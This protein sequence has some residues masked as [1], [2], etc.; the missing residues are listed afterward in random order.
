[1]AVS[2]RGLE[3]EGVARTEADDRAPQQL[4][5]APLDLSLR[6]YLPRES[7]GG[8]YLGK[9]VAWVMVLRCK[10][11]K[12][13]FEYSANDLVSALKMILAAGYRCKEIAS[14]SLSRRRQNRQ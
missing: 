4:A 7:G 1:M 13:D 3:H 11:T 5:F 12:S 6:D 9:I 14:P 8:R 2:L 10:S